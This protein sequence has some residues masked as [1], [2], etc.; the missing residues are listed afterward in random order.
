MRVLV[1]GTG[2]V[3]GY[4]GALLG[5]AGHD[6]HVIA[7]GAHLDALQTHGLAVETVAEDDFT[8]PVHALPA[9]G[10]AHKADLVIVAVKS[11]DLE[12]A[13]AKIRPAVTPDTTV[14]T[15]LN[16][17]ESGERL[18]QVFGPERVLDGVVYIES[19]V[20]S[21]GVIAQVGGPRR[22]VFGNRNGANGEREQRFYQD[23]LAAGWQVE[24]AESVVTALWS[25][26]AYLGPYAAFNTVTGLDSAQLCQAPDCESLMQRMVE[27]Y[28]AVGNTEG[29]AFGDDA[30]AFI[31]DRY[32]NPLVGQTS[33]Y[34]D[35][36]GGR[37]IEAD[38]LVGAV[39][40]RGAA[41]GVPTPVTEMIYSMLKPMAAGGTPPG[42]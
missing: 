5:R 20:K 1:M 21:P 15:L 11:Y 8:I 34:R 14:L 13:I 17:V 40:R 27:E 38:A 37:R 42:A 33:M 4:F 26:Y 29:A 16:G 6:L 9:P 3:G 25:K 10:P 22:A 41:A 32:R 19:F 7:R 28:V 36:L 2:G 18:A 23:F 24:L 31:I 30:V 12:E 39:V 35:R